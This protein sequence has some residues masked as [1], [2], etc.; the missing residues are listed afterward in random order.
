MITIKA[1]KRGTC[2]DVKRMRKMYLSSLACIYHQMHNEMSI[3][4]KDANS[5]KQIEANSREA[6]TLNLWSIN[7]DARTNI[8]KRKTEYEQGE[9]LNSP[10]LHPTKETENPFELELGTHP[11]SAPRKYPYLVNE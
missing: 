2:L 7:K 9:R 11:N 1:R 3:K 5:T 10:E 4:F 6:E 8:V